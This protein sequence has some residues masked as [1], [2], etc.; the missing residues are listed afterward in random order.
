M[1]EKYYT[2]KQVGEILQI[3]QYTVLKWIREGKLK[4]LKF[5]RVYRSTESDLAEFLGT[6]RSHNRMSNQM[7]IEKGEIEPER[8]VVATSVAS[9]IAP[10]TRQ[11]EKVDHYVL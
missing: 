8:P 10:F 9:T 7:P 4:A 1:F 11:E 5:G 6:S 2:P 3:H